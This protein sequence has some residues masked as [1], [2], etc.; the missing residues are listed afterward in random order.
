MFLEYILGTAKSILFFVVCMLSLQGIIIAQNSVGT[1]LLQDAF[2]DSIPNKFVITGDQISNLP[3]RGFNEYL[4]LNSFI[5][6]QDGV[7]HIRGGG[8]NE[9]S[10]FINGFNLTN[11]FGFPGI[12]IIPESINEINVMP[13]YF[14]AAYNSTGTALV[15][16]TLKTGSSNFNTAF[17][18]QTDKFASAGKKYLGGYSYREHIFTG[19]AQGSVLDKH[20]YFVAVENHDIGDTQKRFSKGFD[21]NNL[22]EVYPETVNPEIISSLSYPDGFTPGNSRNRWAV[23]SIFSFNF[24]PF[25]IELTGL[26]D[27]SKFYDDRTPMLTILN[28]RDFFTIKETAFLGANFIYD[29]KQKSQLNVKFGYYILNSEKNDDYFGNDLQKWADSS[30][31]VKASNG[32]VGFEDA[33]YI[34]DYILNGFSFEPPG[35]YENYVKVKHTWMEA[36]INFKTQF[37]QNHKVNIGFDMRQFSLRQYSIDPYIMAYTDPDYFYQ[38]YPSAKDIPE[39]IYRKYTVNIFGYDFMGNEKESKSEGPKEPL[40]AG[41]FLDYQFK[42]KNF[43][44][45][46]SLRYNYFDTKIE[47]GG[48]T[49]IL[50]G[51]KWDDLKPLTSWDPRLSLKYFWN[52]NTSFCVNYGINTKSPLNYVSYANDYKQVIIGGTYYLVPLFDTIK[53]PTQFSFFELGLIKNF[54]DF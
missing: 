3:V 25:K 4:E 1:D 44:L 40:F 30:E 10:Y 20:H 19:V 16:T 50:S 48:K 41:S 33:W 37:S 46:G 26:Y 28:D 27:W 51:F 22:T 14:S 13:G 15:S 47:T 43:S 11:P 35:D 42:Y 17:N 34:E 36:G 31:V 45:N 2:L 18:F 6:F 8:A 49:D 7:L 52:R 54:S 9:N 21:F 53:E 5:S 24:N 12:Y 38:N 23:N 32:H 29:F 39:D